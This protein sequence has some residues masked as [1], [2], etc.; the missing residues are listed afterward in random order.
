METADMFTLRY[1][2]RSKRIKM[3]K[4]ESGIKDEKSESEE[5]C[6]SS[7]RSPWTPPPNGRRAGCAAT[8]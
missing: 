4:S 2:W 3:K 5:K 6:E 8:K 7:P 1:Y